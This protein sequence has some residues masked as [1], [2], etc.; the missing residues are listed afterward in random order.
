MSKPFEVKIKDSIAH[1]IF[2][3]PEKRNSITLEFWTAFPDEVNKLNDRGDIRALIISATGPTFCAGLDLGMMNELEL[4]ADNNNE[5]GRV[6]GHFREQVLEMQKWASCIEDARFPVITAI[7]GGCIGG[8]IDLI[9][10]AD[11]RVASTDAFFVVEEINIGIVADIGTL[12]RLPTIIP[13]GIA[14]EWALTGDKVSSERAYEVGL[15]NHIT[16]DHESA[17]V[18]AFE[19]A[20]NLASKSP[21]AMWGTKEVIN[22]S[23]DHSIQDGL[24]F[25]SLWNAA[26]LHP[27]DVTIAAMAKMQKKKPVYKDIK[28]RYYLKKKK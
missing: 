8:G 9:C 13:A 15:L 16:T 1:I 23:R 2:N 26:M 22:Y 18:K 20:E 6:R 21:L 5:V 19:I 4:T 12:Q 28:D 10:A 27:E 7:Q 25:V 14:R 24:N 11:I 17:L 3:R